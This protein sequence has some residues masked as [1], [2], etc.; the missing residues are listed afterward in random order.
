MLKRSILVLLLL[1]LAASAV[2][3]VANNSSTFSDTI[4]MLPA[5]ELKHAA[6]LGDVQSQFQLAWQYSQSE[7]AERFPTIA[8]NP[9]LAVRWYREAARRGHAPSAYNMAVILAQGRGIPADSVEAFAWLDFAARLGHKPSQNLRD[10]FSGPLSDAEMQRVR[11]L[12]ARLI[13]ANVLRNAPN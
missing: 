6:E 8:Y 1:P 4:Y 2:N 10:E 5:A 12:Q 3:S 11:S 7:A 9:R 13:P